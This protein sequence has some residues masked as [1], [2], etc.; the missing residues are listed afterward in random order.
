MTQLTIFDAPAVR[1]HAI[2]QVLTNAGTNWREQAMDVIRNM[3]G[4]FIGEDVR[5]LC[6]AQ[7]LTAHHP[8]AWGGLLMAAARAGIIEPTGAYRAPVSVRTH[9]RKSQV[10][11]R[12]V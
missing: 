3:P 4:E 10:Y 6:E 8:N 1:D 5:L 9:A 2:A 12:K 11:R 7:G